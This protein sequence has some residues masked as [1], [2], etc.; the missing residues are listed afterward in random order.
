MGGRRADRLGLN[1][2]LLTAA[3]ALAPHVSRLPLWIVLVCA[4][5]LLWRFAV[6]NRAWPAPARPL[7]L[8]LTLLTVAAV[9]QYYGTLLGQEAGTALLASLLA[10]KF[11]EV[12]RLR[13]C[14]VALFL[15]YLLLVAGFLYSQS[16]AVAL[17]S[18]LVVVF[19]VA[20]LVRLNQPSGIDL[21]YA[22]GLATTL[23]LKAVPLM[24]AMFLLF[25]R[26]QGALWRLPAAAGGAVT[27]MS[28]VMEPGSVRNLSRSYAPAFRVEFDGLVPARSQMY[29][30]ALVLWW[31]NGRRWER[32]VPPSALDPGLSFDHEGAPVKYTVTL[33]PSPKPWLPVLDLPVFAPKGTRA[34]P[35][36]LLERTRALRERQRYTVISYPRYRTGALDPAQRALGLQLPQRLSPRVRALARAWRRQSA[37]DLG[38]ARAAMDYFR[39]Q[40]FIYTLDPPPVGDDPVDEFLFST[41]RGFCGY[42]AAAFV[43]L[44]RVAGVPS[45]IVQGY[46]GGEY[47]PAGDYWIVRQADAHAWA[48]VWVPERGWVRMDPTA[49]VAPE[50]VELGID[51]ISRLASRGIELGR[52]PTEAVRRL[53][54]LGWLGGAWRTLRLYWDWG[55]LRWRRGVL[56]YD[57]Q[58]QQRLLR[59]LRL[60]EMS[61]RGLVLTLALVVSVTVLILA[62]ATRRAR[63]A[64]PVQ[65]A[66]RAFCRKLGRAGIRR[67][68]AEGALAFAAR[69]AGA[70][71][72]LKARVDAITGLYVRLRYAGLAG[73][74]HLHRLRQ[75]VA[76][77]RPPAA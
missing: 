73:A 9:F 59:S 53:M 8:S 17:Y 38:V 74:R 70:R 45:R 67:H 58:Q 65:A 66:Y 34:R 16:P 6:E 26:I 46:L 33:E 77:F 60:P 47:N 55:N 54:E 12:R 18:A 7:R 27:G 40:P 42:Y 11:L 30:R 4:G 3:L 49:A 15:S 10:L 14:M 35:G 22:L 51:A 63:R 62:V 25:P 71:P 39:Q 1:S 50:R 57:R 48:E 37:D 36:Y 69:A 2:L 44:M 21:R 72:D 61:W 24:L 5:S 29:W 64:D 32:G 41:R 75:L 23:S 19:S 43:T 31:T 68:P 76:R 28:E 13:D 56:G 20:T 52:L